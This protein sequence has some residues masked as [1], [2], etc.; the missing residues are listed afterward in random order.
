MM[1][2][3]MLAIDE[4]SSKRGHQYLM[5]TADATARKVMFVTE[6][7]SADTITEFRE[8]LVGRL[9]RQLR[10]GPEALERT[11]LRRSHGTEGTYTSE[12]ESWRP[13]AS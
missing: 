8:F 4:T 2:V 5:F 7:K 1:D 3:T 9:L 6:G 12:V 13:A 10:V 11:V